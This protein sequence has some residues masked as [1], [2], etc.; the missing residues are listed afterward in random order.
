[1]FLKQDKTMKGGVM[2]KLRTFSLACILVLTVL[3]LGACGKAGTQQ[4]IPGTLDTGTQTT[5]QKTEKPTGQ[6]AEKSTGN[7][8]EASVE[9]TAAAQSGNRE[10]PALTA[11]EAQAIALKHAGFTADQVTRLHTEYEVDHGVPKY[12]VEFDQGVWEYDC[13][14]HADTG[15]VISFS[16]DN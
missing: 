3:A 2:M 4:T 14:I 7:T 16:K 12:E 8:T 13:E 10:S 15:E 1:M 6:K 11:E 9:T 5:E